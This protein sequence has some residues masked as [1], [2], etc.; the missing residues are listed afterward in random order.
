LEEDTASILSR[1][2]GGSVFY[3]NN[4]AHLQVRTKL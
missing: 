1:E 2:D 4:G 3:G